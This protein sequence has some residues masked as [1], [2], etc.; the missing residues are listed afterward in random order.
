MPRMKKSQWYVDN[1]CS[2]HITRDSNKFLNLEKK[3]KRNDYKR[4]TTQR[5][6]SPKRYQQLFL[7]YFFTCHN[8]GHTTLDC[9]AYRKNYF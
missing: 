6:T 7:G 1:R 2:K 3:E 4:N 9:K 5:R 8:F